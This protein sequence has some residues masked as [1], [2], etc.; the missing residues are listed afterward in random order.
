MPAASDPTEL[1]AVH[2]LLDRL[3]AKYPR[4]AE[5]VKLRYF[6]GCSQKETVH[7][8]GITEDTAQDDWASPGPG[9]APAAPVEDARRLTGIR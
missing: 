3:A 8:L 5:V 7:V 1:L 4:K 2:E 9:S 6:L